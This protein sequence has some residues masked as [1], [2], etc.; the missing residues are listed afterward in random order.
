M[1]MLLAL[2]TE[3]RG[4]KSRKLGSL[5]KLEK[6]GKRLS[7]IAS[8]GKTTLTLWFQPRE[9]HIRFFISRYKTYLEVHCIYKYIISKKMTF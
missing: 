9:T 5:W 4:N 1:A 8:E 2:K 6:G 7:P 3:E